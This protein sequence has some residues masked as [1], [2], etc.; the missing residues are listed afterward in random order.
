[1]ALAGRWKLKGH[2]EIDGYVRI[3]RFYGSKEEGLNAVVRVYGSKAQSK[4]SPESFHEEF[5]LPQSATYD[6]MVS[7]IKQAYQALKAA[8]VDG[9]ITIDAGGQPFVTRVADPRFTNL[10]DT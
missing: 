5:N 2:T 9:P 3:H 7:P 4:T 10:V 1:M 6:D 8:K